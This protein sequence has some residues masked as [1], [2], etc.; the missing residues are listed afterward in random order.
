MTYVLN[1]AQM[2]AVD[3]RAINEFGLPARILMENAG[4]G[5]ADYLM[6]NHQQALQ[7]KV[8][9]LHGCG[10]NSGDGF[11]IAR[12]LFMAGINVALFK[13]LDGKFS[14]ESEANYQLCEK[15]GIVH[16]DLSQTYE[17]DWLAGHLK[18]ATLI[19][20]AIFGIGFRG[21]LEPSL[22]QLFAFIKSCRATCIAI[23]IPSGID[24]D[25]G[26][27]DDSFKAHTTLCI[28][29]PKIGCLLHAGKFNSGYLHTIPI[30]IP[31]SYN[32]AENPATLISEENH[33]TP[34][35]YH[36]A[37]KGMYG[38]VYVIGGSPGYLGSVAMSARSAL[39]AGAGFVNLLSR[40]DLEPY[41]S[42]QPSEIMFI[43]IPEDDKDFVPA[44]ST[45]L[46][47]LS[48]AD[49]I[50]IGPG[51]GLDSF[52]MQVL[53]L[54]LQNCQVPTVVDADAIRL[55]AQTPKL[56]KYLKKPNILLTPHY[57][58]FCALAGTE[59][60]AIIADHQAC[61][62][63]FVHKYKARILL[64]GDTTVFY[65]NRQVY[66]STRGNDGLATGGSGDVLGGIIASFAAQGLELGRAA[67]NASYLMGKTAEFLAKKRA[68]PSIIPSDIIENLF[69]LE[70]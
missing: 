46:A 16:F 25:T 50:L 7:G 29:A 24:A 53:E 66:F 28:H 5:C 37:H 44:K 55:I 4:K 17:P 23:D 47:L 68:T 26:C 65:D 51:L 31:A 3:K 34:V 67:I 21:K 62:A 14:P 56:M 6:Q 40:M 52:A 8:I 38:R 19:I 13:V 48:K 63:A 54:V 30:G 69:V 61:L 10:N 33:E 35:R 45:F 43:P 12:W 49:S 58:E 42:M 22:L 70:D 64:K 60:P 39:R 1:S 32:L 11:V 27:G 15:L 20:D 2:K 18:T 9:I 59:I 57:G 36:A 41:Y